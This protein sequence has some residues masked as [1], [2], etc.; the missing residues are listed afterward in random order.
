MNKLKKEQE[1]AED[2][3]EDQLLVELAQ[4]G[5]L[6]AFDK[7]VLRHNKRLY[8]TVYYMTQN[9]DD[10]YDLLQDIFAKAYRSIKKFKGKSSFYTWIYT[11]A[12]N[13]TINHLKK[14]K[15]QAALSIDD[16][17]SGVHNDR[18][19]VS[20]GAKTDPRREADLKILQKRLNE[21]LMKLSKEHRTVVVLF[22]IEGMPHSQISS[23][24]GV[25]EGTIRSR[26]FYA[27]QNLQTQLEEFKNAL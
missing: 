1:R 18:V 22:D 17:T 11:I 21:A 19:F 25:S 12:V 5:D 3:K 14:K 24:L 7:L 15:R 16:E 6:A 8:N 4:G 20:Q 13:M 9:R 10:S 23:I 27:H 2:V 26:L